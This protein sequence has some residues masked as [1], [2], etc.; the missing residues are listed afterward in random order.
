MTA[1]RTILGEQFQSNQQ[2]GELRL[3]RCTTC[4]AFQYP[5][6]EVCRV[7]LSDALTW[8]AVGAGVVTSLTR[9]HTTNEP[10]L[11]PLLPFQ[12]AS[13]RAE[14]IQVIAFVPD[15]A[16]SI[17][18]QVALTAVDDDGGRFVA[19]AVPVGAKIGPDAKLTDVLRK[20]KT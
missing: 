16:A 11:Q 4:S 18:E 7:C 5:T 13:I 17:G 10:K 2:T 3:Q 19:C 15:G 14:G 12:I 9:L 8:E 1:D 20:R 6:R